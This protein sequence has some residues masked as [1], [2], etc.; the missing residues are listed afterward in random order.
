VTFTVFDVQPADEKVMLPA[1]FF[2]VTANPTDWVPL[3]LKEAGAT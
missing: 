3:T 2:T 1:C